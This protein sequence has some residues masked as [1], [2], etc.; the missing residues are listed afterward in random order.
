ML[1]YLKAILYPSYWL[2]HQHPVP[3][4]WLNILSVLFGILA[5]IGLIAGILSWRKAFLAPVRTL[6]RTI[7]GFGLTMGLVGG[8][9][10]FFSVQQVAFLSARLWY[11]VWG[12]AAL[13][14]LYQVL[15][16]AF[17]VL[18]KRF[19]EQKERAQREK[20]LPKAGK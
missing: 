12:V 13:L 3:M 4:T 14:W 16:Y 11:L 7:S 15:S 17:F 1:S 19:A 10:L 18:P 2:T 9:M 6:L 20:Y 5:A 8:L